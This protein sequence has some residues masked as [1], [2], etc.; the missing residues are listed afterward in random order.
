MTKTW[1]KQISAAYRAWAKVKGRT[2][3]Y[4]IFIMGESQEPDGFL[5]H[6]M[7]SA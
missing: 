4:S 1:A 7:L 6:I 5:Q 3:F 2:D